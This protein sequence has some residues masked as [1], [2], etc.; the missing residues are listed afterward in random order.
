MVEGVFEMTFPGA[1]PCRTSE[2]GPEDRGAKSLLEVLPDLEEVSTVVFA[3]T[4]TGD[5]FTSA[6]ALSG[7]G[8]FTGATLTTVAFGFVPSDAF[9]SPASLPT[10]TSCVAT[11]VNKSGAAPEASASARSWSFLFSATRKWFKNS[12]CM[13]WPRASASRIMCLIFTGSG[14][15]AIAATRAP[16]VV[17]AVARVSPEDLADV[18]VGTAPAVFACV[19]SLCIAVGFLGM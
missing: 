10:M 2:I 5:G 8:A 7:A 11:S 12:T 13:V 4:G 19:T 16:I 9:S 14:A 6:G 3:I 17:A 18:D 1:P 15:A